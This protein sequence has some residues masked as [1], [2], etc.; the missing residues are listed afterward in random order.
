M[1]MKKLIIGI[2]SIAIIVLG[3]LLFLNYSKKQKELSFYQQFSSLQS[4]EVSEMTKEEWE[5]RNWVMVDIA[6]KLGNEPDT[7]SYEKAKNQKL[8]E[9]VK[10]YQEQ[11]MQRALICGD[12]KM[13][14]AFHEMM[15]FNMPTHKYSK[16]S[17]NMQ[18]M[19]DC[20]IQINVTTREPQNYNWKTF[21][22]FE[23]YYD[24][25]EG[26]YRMKTIKR[27]FLG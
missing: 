24:E 27:D 11:Q 7:I 12:E 21:W 4:K 18:R 5:V 9:D 6:T 14:Q 15:E 13:I 20:E 10:Q 25:I 26:N 3:V 17:I 2:Q 19:D 23:V 8:A 16:S 1:K 22:V